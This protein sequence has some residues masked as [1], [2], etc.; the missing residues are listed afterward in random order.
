M[1]GTVL[2]GYSPFQ[3]S[4]LIQGQQRPDAEQGGGTEAGPASRVELQVRH[5]LP[6]GS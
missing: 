3:V 5:C 2:A 6:W 1:D 4:S